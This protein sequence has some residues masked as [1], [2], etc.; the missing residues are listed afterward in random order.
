MTYRLLPTLVMLFGTLALVVTPAASAQEFGDF[1]VPLVDARVAVNF[2]H[3]DKDDGAPGILLAASVKDLV[4]ASTTL[5]PDGGARMTVWLRTLTIPA[6]GASAAGV[7]YSVIVDVEGQ[8][9]TDTL[10]YTSR[11]GIDD[12]ALRIV[13]TLDAM[14]DELARTGALATS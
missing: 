1:P 7:A 2:I 13:T 11:D 3:V 4:A 9:V 5:R 6:T 10:G 12:S 8:H 14:A